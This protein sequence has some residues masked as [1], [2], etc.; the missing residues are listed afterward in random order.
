MGSGDDMK[1]L[2]EKLTAKIDDVKTSIDKLAP[3]AR[4]AE[5]LTTLPSKVVALQSSAFENQEQVRALNLAIPRA[6]NAQREGRAHAEEN[7]NTTCEGSINRARQG[8]VP[9]L[10]NNRQP[11]K[12]R[13]RQLPLEQPT[14]LSPRPLHGLC[15]GG[16]S[17]M[18][19]ALPGAAGHI[20]TTGPFQSCTKENPVASLANGSGFVF[21]TGHRPSYRFGVAISWDRSSLGHTRWLHA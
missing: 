3:L 11:P 4:V 19:Q 10:E 12:D 15:G 17:H 9:V 13:F 20:G 2:I 14:K 6:E 5:Q 1:E 16:R 21:C 8:P 18:G 7:G